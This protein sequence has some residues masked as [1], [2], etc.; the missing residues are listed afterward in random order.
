[1]G[2]RSSAGRSALRSPRGQDNAC[3]GGSAPESEALIPPACLLRASQAAQR[4]E[5]EGEHERHGDAE[6][7][8][9]LGRDAGE[10]AAP[11]LENA[12]D[13]VDVA[14]AWIQPSGGASGT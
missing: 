11:R 6:R 5:R 14:T 1:M 2:V 8:P 13:R 10:E 4:P 3:P 7:E 12:R 9:D